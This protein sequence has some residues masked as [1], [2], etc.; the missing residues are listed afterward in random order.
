MSNFRAYRERRFLSQLI[1]KFISVLK[2]IP[3]SGNCVSYVTLLSL[4]LCVAEATDP[5]V[6][7]LIQVRLVVNTVPVCMD[8]ISK[9]IFK[10]VYTLKMKQQKATLNCLLFNMYLVKTIFLGT[11][12]LYFVL[13]ALRHFI[14]T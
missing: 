4:N 6:G 1:Q 2:S 8:F 9:L 5:E 14:Y 11:D 12:I 13:R 10:Y 3:V 7:D